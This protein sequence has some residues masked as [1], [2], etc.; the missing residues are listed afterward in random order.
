MKNSTHNPTMMIKSKFS[1][2]FHKIVNSCYG[3]K[4]NS[5]EFWDCKRNE[6]NNP[7]TEKQKAEL[8]DEVMKIY[9]EC[10]NELINYFEDR[11]Y[12]KHVKKE[13]EKKLLVTQ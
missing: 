11:S 12:K 1:N 9:N 13:R 7:L 5:R 8:F 3:I 4:R 2:Q 10:S 6:R